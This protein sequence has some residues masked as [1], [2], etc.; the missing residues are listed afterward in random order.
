MKTKLF[1]LG[2]ALGLGV[3]SSG[4][5][6]TSTGTINV[7]LTLT[8]GCLVNGQPA[9][10]TGNIALG[11]LD[12]GTSTTIFTDLNA[13][14]VGTAGNGIWVRC[15]TGSTPTVQVTGS[16]NTA[17]AEPTNIFGAVTTAPRYLKTAADSTRAIAYSLY[18]TD[19]S[20]TPIANGVNLTPSATT[21]PT[22]GTNYPIYGRI[23]Q[24]GNN[25]LIPAGVYTDTIT[26]AINY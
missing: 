13:V 1:L 18:P 14:L 22:L 20:T 7:T 5:A 8:N 17:P 21:S 16:T 10:A 15:T 2:C 6:A 26:V 3:A 4:F 12:F 19:T 11:T 25:P 24:G 23:T 9:P